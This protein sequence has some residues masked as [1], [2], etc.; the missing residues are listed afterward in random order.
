MCG[1][2]GLTSNRLPENQIIRA[3]LD[4]IKHRGPDDEGYLFVNTND[5]SIL[6]VSG[7]HSHTVIRDVFS[8]VSY[9]NA[10][11]YNL[12]LANRRLSILDVSPQGHQPMGYDDGDIW[13]TYNG[14]IFNYREIKAE[15]Q[16]IGHRFQSNSDTEVVLAA[17]S[18]WGEECVKRFN[19]QWAFC[20]YDRRKKRIFCSRDRFGIKPLYYWFDGKFFAFASEIKTLLKLPYVRKELNDHLIFD[21]VFFTLLDHTEESLFRGIYQ[22]LPAHNLSLD[23][24]AMDMRRE[25][26]YEVFYNEDIG[27][28]DHAQALKYAD[29]IR[30]LLIDAV[31]MSLISD[32]PVGSCLSGG[33]DSSAIVVII[34][35]LLKEGGISSESIGEKQKT[36]TAAFHDPRVD[37]KV[38][39]EEIIR[40]TDVNAF[41][42]YPS[43]E[44][45]WEKLERVLFFHDGTFFG[46]NIY[47]GWE[48]MNLASR[49]V[50]VVINGQ[51]GDELFG[52]YQLRYEPIHLADLMKKRKIREISGTLTEM[53]KLYGLKRC[54]R[55]V[56]LGG[57]FRFVPDSLKGFI[58][59]KRSKEQTQL[60]E[61]M[62]SKTSLSGEDVKDVFDRQRSLNYRLWRDVTKDYLPQ[63]LRYD[64]RDSAAA[65]IEN[66]VPFLDYRLVE[67][68]SA[69]PSIYKLH[70][71][72]SK[73]LLRLAM[74]DLLPEGILWRKDKIGFVTPNSAWMYHENS[75]MPQF[76][77]SHGAKEYTPFMWKLF[78]AE[79][80]IDS[81]YFD[82]MTVTQ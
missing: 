58:F 80:L 59:K 46:T 4:S 66:R 70:N 10:D 41:F 45:L 69:I 13:I 2:F 52:G 34:N 38:H 23:L 63:L 64:D 1:I 43:A 54:Y 30:E 42:T 37:E 60:L 44:R 11:R 8:D 20:I 15:L 33:L 50:K 79:K 5:D 62:F 12:L 82:E 22:L 24:N 48:V 6:Q 28:Y 29:D 77:R 78:L 18:A 27:T 51:G 49:H 17:Y 16:R 57:Y 14:E 19:G 47:A 55:G 71:G 3:A 76:M 31:R 56:L 25:R 73:W 53:Y 40:N 75:P 65:S 36:F 67:Y 21:F 81:H 26:Y 7:P 9:V 35:K 32:V 61:H 68:M 74:K 39:A 72:W